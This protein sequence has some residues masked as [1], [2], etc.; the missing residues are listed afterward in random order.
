MADAAGTCGQSIAQN[1]ITVVLAGNKGTFQRKVGHRLVGA[2]VAIL[3]FAGFG[4]CSQG[5]QLVAQADAESWDA[6]IQHIADIG[7]DLHVFCRVTGAVGKHQAIRRKGFELCQGGRSRQHRYTA[8]AL[9]QAAHNVLFAAKVQQG[10]VQRFFALRHTGSGGKAL[11]L[12]AGHGIHRA[13]HGISLDDGHQGSQLFRLGFGVKLG[14]NGTVHNA[15]FAQDAGQAAGIN[16]L[17]ADNAVFFQESIQ[18]F[19]A[20]EV[21]RGRACFAHDV[22]LCPD[23]AALFV[24]AVHAVVADQRVGLGNDLAIVAGVG[25]RFFKPDHTGGKHNFAHGSALAA[26]AFAL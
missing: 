12:G 10:N 24:F 25:Q 15:A 2:A 13:G 5:G 20:A 1:R 4:A 8:A 14:G 16:A 23:L 22:T 18:R 11:R 3:H 17:N 26:Q 19:L 6:G 9:T 21:G 7:D